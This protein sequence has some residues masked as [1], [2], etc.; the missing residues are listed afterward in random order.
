MT[1]GVSN[2]QQKLPEATAKF[3]WGVIDWLIGTY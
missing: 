2:I 3:E 1:E